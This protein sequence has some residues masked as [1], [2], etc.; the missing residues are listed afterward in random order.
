M[1]RIALHISRATKVALV[2]LLVLVAM[3]LSVARLL[4]PMVDDLREQVQEQ[5]SA[6]VGAPV[7]LGELSGSVVNFNLAVEVSELT[8]FQPQHP[9]QT[10]LQLTDI[11]LELDT[12]SSLTHM[13]PVFQRISIGDGRLMVDGQPGSLALTGFPASPVEAHTR[14]KRERAHIR[15]VLD[16]IAQQRLIDFRD[17]HFVFTMPSGETN[18]VAVRRMVLSGSPVNRRLAAVIETDT[19]Q[20]VNLTMHLS[21]RAYSWPDV[22]L[23]GYVSVPSIDLKPW[24]PLLP[25]ALKEETGLQINQL[26]SGT[27]LWFSYTPQ[28]WDVRGQVR[29]DM[30]DVD[31][32]GQTLPP[33][34]A[35]R[36]D[37][38]LTFSREEPPRLWLNDLSFIYSGF[39]YPESNLFMEWRD[40]GERSFTLT[41]DTV[42]LQPLALAITASKQM[43]KIVD[44]V[45]ARLAPRGRLNN[46]VLRT[47]PDRKPFDFELTADMRN[48]GVDHYYGAPSGERV[49]GSFRMNA[50]AGVIDVDSSEF[51]LGLENV[52]DDVWNFDRVVGRLYWHIVDDVYVL[53]S[54]G[55]SLHG[56]EGV[57]N[58]RLRLDI[59][60]DASKNI[61]MALEAGVV[62]GDIA[63]AGKYLPTKAAMSNELSDWLTGAIKGG[64]I[65]QGAFIWNGPLTGPYVPNDT[66]WGLFFDVSKTA[67]AFDAN[68]PAVTD[69]DGL[70]SV[71]QDEALVRADKARL[72]DSRLSGVTAF[73][74]E[75]LGNKPLMLNIKGQ[76]AS[77]GV[78]GLRIL[79][80]TPVAT[81]INHA[82]DRWSM[83]GPLAVNL[84]LDIP[85]TAGA[86]GDYRIGVRLNNNSFTVP[87]ANITG[88]ALN[89]EVLYSSKGLSGRD[90]TGEVFGNPA[91]LN[92]STRKTGKSETTLL[93]VKSRVSMETLSK[94]LGQ[95][96]Y[97]LATGETDYRAKVSIGNSVKVDVTSDLTGV[98]T[99][100]PA[101]LSKSAKDREPIRVSVNVAKGQ[102]VTVRA[103][104]EQK[105][106]LGMKLDDKGRL[107]SVGA[108]FGEGK[109]FAP[110]SLYP[111]TGILLTG[112]L[113]E[114]QLQPWVQ[115]WNN[116]PFAGDALEESTSQSTT[117]A[118]QSSTGL[119]SHIEVKNFGVRHLFWSGD[120][121][122]FSDSLVDISRD[123]QAWD[124]RFVAPD[125]VGSVSVLG[126]DEPLKVD[127]D[128]LDIPSSVLPQHKV[129]TDEQGRA[130]PLPPEKDDEDPLEQVDPASLPDMNVTIRKIR[131]SGR[132][133]GHLSFNGRGIKDGVQVNDIQGELGNG[134]FDGSLTW[135]LQNKLHKTTLTASFG[136]SDIETMLESWGYPNLLTAKKLDDRINL[137]W[138]GSPADFDMNDLTGDLTFD[139]RDGRFL[140][141]DTAS[142]ALR[143]FGVLNLDAITRRLRLDFSDLYS[144]G[145]AFDSVKGKMNF[146]NGLITF[147]EP[148]VV[149]GPA[150]D[151]HLG[152][153]LY[154]PDRSLNMELVV[155]LPVTQ[156]LS[157]VSLLLGQPY[158]AG[159][160]YLFDK[161]LG[162]TV[163]PFA[164]LRYEI[165]GSFS[166]PEVR[167]DRLFS[168]K[169]GSKKQPQKR[170]PEALQRE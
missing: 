68:W 16:L 15:R 54:D 41:A 96:F 113:N 85:L 27:K 43:P 36:S 83:T 134:V 79:Q 22:M 57:L 45:V 121:E 37:I 59:P 2:F 106:V 48:V 151:L 147:S 62:D 125:L 169:V 164:S 78:D 86:E 120:D 50:N 117:P 40:K 23:G 161:L 167:L 7:D 81:A 91:S 47:Y 90:L 20:E 108:H 101:P 115:W 109:L 89:G 6:V 152:G 136:S 84:D 132:D 129:E 12:L 94:W 33:L 31:W 52:F 114:L 159:A 110:K 95:D 130:I 49:N 8:V 14:P 71:D 104:L 19:G 124:V 39:P 154:V 72:Y 97:G 100:L 137:N 153:Q 82:A 46:F 133:F 66:S 112:Q 145:M 11:V 61:W 116:S 162:S 53:R 75:I 123:G 111:E 77:D 102:P 119:L 42:H 88:N 98:A 38:A 69:I 21:G 10:S 76:A 80:E 3:A 143:L 93:D 25:K 160:T 127:I 18:E 138:Q 32:K 63:Y 163:E 165:K 103:E 34:T 56:G 148:V 157:V 5:I 24:L 26:H 156:N 131:L 58:T 17:L 64:D 1:K 70:V 142:G 158:I 92:L 150:T 35:L 144:S 170:D 141:V 168:N 4:L 122:I 55:L 139:I 155:T 44:D 99:T 74:P 29:S 118:N 51:T 135:R 13:Q 30:L 65:R 128:R 166:E 126:G 67:F 107:T 146:Q 73:V 105:A 149:K 87:E 60:F 28:G 9:A 140:S